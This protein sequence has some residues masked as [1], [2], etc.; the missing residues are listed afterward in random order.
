MR[1]RTIEIPTFTEICLIAPEEVKAY[2]EK[3]RETPQSKLWHPEGNVFIHT[4]IVYNRARRTG[5]INYAVAALFHDLGK[6]EATFKNETTGRWSAKM[7]ERISAKLVAKHR[8]WVESLGA[9]YDIVHYIV[10]QHMRVK[11][12]QEMRPSKREVFRK[13]PF[14][15]FVNKFSEFDD[16]RKDYSR[17]FDE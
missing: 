12:I 15:E 14:F 11:H 10:D 16:M 6:V 2:I 8:N 9:D 1:A 7:H 13:E 5:N 3:C 17:D 4:N